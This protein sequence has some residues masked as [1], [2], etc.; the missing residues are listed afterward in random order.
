M[1]EAVAGRGEMV[2]EMKRM[3]SNCSHREI[4]RGINKCLIKKISIH[5]IQIPC[6]EHTFARHREVELKHGRPSGYGYTMP[7]RG[8]LETD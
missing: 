6:A 4:G 1:G 2:E 5:K 3:C 8:E 7:Y